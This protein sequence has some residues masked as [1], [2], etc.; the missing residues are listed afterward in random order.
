[1]EEILLKIEKLEALHNLTR[2]S[3][4]KMQDEIEKLKVKMIQE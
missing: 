4:D 2:D 3:L 1:M